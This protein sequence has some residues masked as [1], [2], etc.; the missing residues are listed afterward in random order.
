MQKNILDIMLNEKLSISHFSIEINQ[1]LKEIKTKK[2][3]VYVAKNPDQIYYKVG[4]TKK[5]P[6]ERARTLKTAGVIKEFNIIF[7]LDFLD[8]KKAE[9]TIHNKLEKFHVS[10]EFFS[11][12]PNE[13]VTEIVKYKEYEKKQCEQYMN[14]EKVMEDISLLETEIYY[15]F[16]KK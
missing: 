3:W 11:T 8:C 9:K 4:F 6:N 13:I 1:L 15:K 16:R 7:A 2:G 14:Y 10:G 5:N 12:L